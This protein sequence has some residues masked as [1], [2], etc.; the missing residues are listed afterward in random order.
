MDNNT[1]VSEVQ[2]VSSQ[3]GD[4]RLLR[5]VNHLDASDANKRR[6]EWLWK[7]LQTQDYWFDD[8]TRG[9]PEL[10]IATLF[11]P[12][13][14]HYEVGDDGYACVTQIR[15]ECE[16]YVHFAVWNVQR[17]ISLTLAAA[18]ELLDHLFATYQLNRITATMPVFNQKAI[19]FATLLGFKYEGDVR[20]VVR[21]NGV[22]YNLCVYGLLRDEYASVM[23]R[24]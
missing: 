5:R 20:K 23:R 24:N 22:F 15:P 11:A 2:R 21:K 3:R 9:K 14:E 17:D 19:K 18:R 13:T 1:A 4:L 10:F 6:I 16:A 7:Q 12:D 8:F